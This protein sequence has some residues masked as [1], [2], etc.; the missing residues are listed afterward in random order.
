MADRFPKTVAWILDAQL[1]INK[2]KKTNLHMFD[3]D[4]MNKYDTTGL[5]PMITKNIL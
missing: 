5:S 1:D 2:R 4:F 3:D